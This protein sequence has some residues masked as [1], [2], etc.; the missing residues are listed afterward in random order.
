MRT[1]SSGHGAFVQEVGAATARDP[2]SNAKMP[3][4]FPPPSASIIGRDGERAMIREGEDGD[5]PA[6]ARLIAGIFAEYEGCLFDPREFPE[7]AAVATHYAR[8]GGKIWVAE[9]RGPGLVIACAAVMRTTLPARHELSKVYVH[10]D[11]RGSGLARALVRQAVDFAC[12]AGARDLELFTDTRFN[13]AHPFYRKLG[14]R[15]IAGERYLA[16]VSRSWEY[17]FHKNLLPDEA[18]TE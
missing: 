8:A 12:R 17:H 1:C 14:F 7:F 13:L 3:Q 4:T 18:N 9:A 11:W 2:M 10:R 5:G 6:L 15:Q 16:D